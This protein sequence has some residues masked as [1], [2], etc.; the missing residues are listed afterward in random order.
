MTEVGQTVR[1]LIRLIRLMHISESG[2]HQKDNAKVTLIFK[3]QRLRAALICCFTETISEIDASPEHKANR[4]LLTRYK[5]PVTH[6]S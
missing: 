1:E 2:L 3:L 5:K 6:C 4:R